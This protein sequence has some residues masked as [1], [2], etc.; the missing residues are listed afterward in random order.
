MSRAKFLSLL[1][2]N[3]NYNTNRTPKVSIILYTKPILSHILQNAGWGLYRNELGKY[4]VPWTI[5]NKHAKIKA[6]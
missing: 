4:R 5:I 2:F 1:D 3:W 6:L